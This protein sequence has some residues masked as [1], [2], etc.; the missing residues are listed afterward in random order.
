[1]PVVPATQEAEAGGSVRLMNSRFGN[2]KTPSQK[3]ETTKQQEP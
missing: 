2:R 1:M 3:T